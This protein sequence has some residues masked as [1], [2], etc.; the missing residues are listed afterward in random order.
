MHDIAMRLAGGE[1]VDVPEPLI[2]HVDA[3]LT[4]V[5]DWEPRELI[6]ETPVYNRRFMYAG[7]L[8]LIA[9][10]IDGFIWLL[11]FKTAAKGIFPEDAIQL[12]AYRNAEF[13]LDADGVEQPLPQVDRV[14]AIWLRADGYD[15]HPVSAGEREFRLWRYARELARFKVDGPFGSAWSRELV[16]EAAKP[17]KRDR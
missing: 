15:L 14:G 13:Y 2:G 3:Y 8:D 6:V 7:Q 11:D 1:E 9:E 12:S 4:F 16:A 17:P 10:L 5:R